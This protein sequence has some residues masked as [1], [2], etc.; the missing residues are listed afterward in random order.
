L[1]KNRHLNSLIQE[2]SLETNVTSLVKSYFAPLLGLRCACWQFPPLQLQ[3]TL[4]VMQRCPLTVTYCL[5]WCAK[6]LSYSAI[7]N[8]P[9]VVPPYW[10]TPPCHRDGQPLLAPERSTG[11]MGIAEVLLPAERVRLASILVDHSRWCE[12]WIFLGRKTHRGCIS[13]SAL[14]LHM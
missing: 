7:R 9:K 1:P 12:P 8:G 10:P 5:S 2:K 14:N 11:V 4:V 13:V 3:P 6:G